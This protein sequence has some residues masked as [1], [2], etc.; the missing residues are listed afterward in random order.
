M[1]GKV[2]RVHEHRLSDTQ[3][4]SDNQPVRPRFIAL[5]RQHM[6]PGLQ[7]LVI[8]GD[9]APQRL[10]HLSAAAQPWLPKPVM[11]MRLRSWLRSLG[12][13]V[14]AGVAENARATV[15]APASAQRR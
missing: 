3:V 10:A 13:A 11:P 8:T 1:C 4:G 5:L 15:A 9:I 7:A 2:S 12:P 6:G 14:S